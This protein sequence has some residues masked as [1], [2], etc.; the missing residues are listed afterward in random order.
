MKTSSLQE[1]LTLYRG[2]VI[3]DSGE[4][5]SRVRQVKGGESRHLR[6]A[7]CGYLPH[8]AR[9]TSIFWCVLMMA[10]GLLSSPSA[11][12]PLQRFRAS[13]P[14]TT[15]P[16]GLPCGGARVLTTGRAGSGAVEW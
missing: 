4:I 16:L 5:A 9:L 10:F 7:S 11:P 15:I 12:A 3:G 1:T 14:P 6:P 2:K 8:A 13:F